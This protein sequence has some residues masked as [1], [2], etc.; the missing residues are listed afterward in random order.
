MIQQWY[1]AVTTPVL[2]W[3]CTGTTLVLPWCKNGPDKFK[4]TSTIKT[5]SGS[6][7]GLVRGPVRRFWSHVRTVLA[8]DSKVIHLMGSLPAKAVEI[9]EGVLPE[10][11]QTLAVT[12]RSTHRRSP[13]QGA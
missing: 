7:L 12:D 11:A 8:I 4:N 5:P 6:A 1:D 13:C 10:H 9:Q 2:Y 3:H